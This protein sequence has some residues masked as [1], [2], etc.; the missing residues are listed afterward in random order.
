VTSEV[1]NASKANHPYRIQQQ[2]MNEVV[3]AAAPTT[4]LPPALQSSLNEIVERSH[5]L[6]ANIQAILLSTTDG[7]PLGRGYCTVE[8]EAAVASVESSPHCKHMSLLGMG[9]VK[10]VTALYDHGTLLHV[11]QGA[12]VCC[13]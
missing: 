13:C 3:S 9:G 11:Y 2:T 12:M 1:S 5:L 8:D 10:Q 4:R 6:G 7:V